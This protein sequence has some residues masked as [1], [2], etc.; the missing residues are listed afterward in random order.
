MTEY[1]KLNGDHLSGMLTVYVTVILSSLVTTCVTLNSVVVGLVSLTDSVL[2]LSQELSLGYNHGKAEL[3]G[4]LAISS[5]FQCIDG[6]HEYRM[7]TR[8]WFRTA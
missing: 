6:L 1:D 2:R 4:K 8:N 3:T 5:L 7:F